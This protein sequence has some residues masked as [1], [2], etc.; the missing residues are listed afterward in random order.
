MIG[1]F[2][3]TALAFLSSFV[4]GLNPLSTAL[5]AQT[6]HIVG[7][8]ADAEVASWSSYLLASIFASSKEAYACDLISQ[9][10]GNFMENNQ[11]VSDEKKIQSILAWSKI[12]L[13]CTVTPLA[14]HLTWMEFGIYRMPV[15]SSIGFFFLAWIVYKTGFQGLLYVSIFVAMFWLLKDN[16]YVAF[17]IGTGYKLLP[18]VLHTSRG[19]EPGLPDLTK[20]EPR[21]SEVLIYGWIGSLAVFF[22]VVFTMG[23]NPNGVN[24]FFGQGGVAGSIM[25]GLSTFTMEC[26]L[27][28][29]F[30]TGTF[31][32]KA[33]IGMVAKP[34]YL[35]IA[36]V[37]TVILIAIFWQIALAPIS[38]SYWKS[39]I[40]MKGIYNISK[41]VSLAIIGC[42]MVYTGGLVAISCVVFM[43]FMPNIFTNLHAK[44]HSIGP[45]LYILPI[46]G[47]S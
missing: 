8:S 12:I 38:N 35:S 33:G 23:I 5:L 3:G 11:V 22:Y 34:E 18:S 45:I 16:L 31:T 40:K 30:L 24:K 20:E 32:G 43:V 44:D 28:G 47:N 4:P 42:T 6:L 27:L 14:Y 25:R 29:F 13:L 36:A 41:N 2:F 46:A 15:A 19:I 21:L 10:E 39:V 17:F 1:L 37:G 26:I 7:L 9:V